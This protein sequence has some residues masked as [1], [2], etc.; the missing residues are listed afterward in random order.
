[1]TEEFVVIVWRLWLDDWFCTGTQDRRR[2]LLEAKTRI[3]V[4]TGW[5]WTQPFNYDNPPRL[6]LPPA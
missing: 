4:A 2:E 3:E 5:A 6:T 1:M